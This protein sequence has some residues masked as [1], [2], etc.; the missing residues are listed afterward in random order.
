M[1]AHKVLNMYLW[2]T[3]VCTWWNVDY[4]NTDGSTGWRWWWNKKIWEEKWNFYLM[5]TFMMA[6][7][8]NIHAVIILL[9]TSLCNGVKTTMENEINPH[10]QFHCFIFFLSILFC[11]NFFYAEFNV[12]VG[13]CCLF[14]NISENNLFI[15]PSIWKQLVE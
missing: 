6:R 4:G 5:Y 15:L 12:V 1:Q 11:N 14:T 3:D 9:P 8:L 7:M 2:D 13:L 10:M